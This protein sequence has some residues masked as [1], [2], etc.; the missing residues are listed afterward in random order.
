MIEC[1][2]NQIE[3]FVYC[4][5]F[6]LIFCIM[7]KKFIIVPICYLQNLKCIKN[8]GLDIQLKVFD[9]HKEEDLIELSHRLQDIK[10]EFEYP[11]VLKSTQICK[12]TAKS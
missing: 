4:L 3:W 8:D 10:A 5:C 2:K 9:E 11:F 1:Y 6:Y 7:D 12:I